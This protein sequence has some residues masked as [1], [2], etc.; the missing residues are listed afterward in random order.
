MNAQHDADRLIHAF[1]AEGPA[2]L[3]MPLAA[4]IRG[5]IHETKQ[6][7]GFRPWRNLSLPR[8]I[9]V[10]APLAAIVV[11]IGGLLIVSWG[12]P[13]PSPSPTVIPSP[14]AVPTRAPSAG[15][16]AYPLVDGEA[17]I[18]I[19]G[20]NRGSL[21]RSDGTDRHDFLVNIGLAIK[22][23]AW[24]PDGSQIAFEGNG[25][26][27]SEIHIV[28]ADGTNRRQLTPTPDG[29]PA[30]DCIEG[31][32]PAWSPDGSR[33]AYVAVQHQSGG[34]T[35][36]ALTVVDVDT[37]ATTE[38]YGTATEALARP[39][40]SP[41]GQSIA[42]E[43]DRFAGL[44]EISEMR[45]TAIGVIDLAAA[46][47]TP[48]M[49]TDPGL[50]A[51]Y[52]MWHPT[53]DLIVFRTNRLINSGSTSAL[54][55]P[56]AAANVYTIRPDGTGLTQV[57]RYAVGGPVARA[58]SWIPDGRILFSSYGLSSE[59]DTLRVIDVDGTNEGSATGAVTTQGQGRW[60]P[61]T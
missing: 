25:G 40:W 38:I 19:G 61:G 34:F 20:D 2:D 3:S 29:C 36:N 16:T 44:V 1:L 48:R 11:A 60:R 32:N 14:S 30:G 21:I 6:R 42:L 9:W 23:P 27:G 50:L 31:I 41:D 39:T 53:E 57:T 51:G 52:P 45:D 4:R 58:P 24:S 56:E 55:D 33:I 13:K 47:K 15:P 10:V 37:G 59:T 12:G 46:D 5:E 7:A 35:R 28:D 18:V 8:T 43:I 54:L 49:I 17:W 22:D 26:R